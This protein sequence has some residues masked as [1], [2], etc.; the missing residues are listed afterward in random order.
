MELVIGL[1]IGFGAGVIATIEWAIC[2]SRKRGDSD[3][4]NIEKDHSQH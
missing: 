3:G 2:V 1:V 4:E